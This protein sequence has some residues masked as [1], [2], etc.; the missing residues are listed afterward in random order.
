[1]LHHH[2]GLDFGKLVYDQIIAMAANTQTEKTRCIMFP[3]LIQQVIHFQRTITPDLLHDEFT[4]TP[5]L[6]VKDV[7]AGRGS[8]ADSSAA[9]LEDDINR[10]IAGLKA[11]RV[12]LR[13]KGDAQCFVLFSTLCLTN[14]FS[15]NVHLCRGRL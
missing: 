1:M 13:S 11:I 3:N 6:V 10:A 4:G 7:K 2:D 5:K 14:D 8:G 12:R 9:S 15:L